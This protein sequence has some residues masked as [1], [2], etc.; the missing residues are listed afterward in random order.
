MKN[1]LEKNKQFDLSIIIV[2]WNVKE[3][4]IKCLNSIYKHVKDIIFEIYVVDNYSID[5]TVELLEKEFKSIHLIKNSENIGFA[6]ANNQ[7]LKICKGRHVLFLNPDTE[8]ISL[9]IQRMVNVLDKN[10]KIGAVGCKLIYPDGSVYTPCAR[11]FPTPLN[12]FFEIMM[13]RRLFPKSKFFGSKEL[14]YWD[15]NDSREVE[16]LVGA[17]LMVKREVL[18]NIGPFD[19]GYFMY[20]EDID[21]CYRIRKAEWKNYYLSEAQIIH[22]AEASSKKAESKSEKEN[23]TFS[24]IALVNQ[25][26]FQFMQRNYGTKSAYLFRLLIVVGTFTRIFVIF[27]GMLLLNRINKNNELFNKKTLN[28]YKKVLRWALFG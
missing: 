24:K 14:L 12:S 13:L 4:L 27:L 16:C 22:H 5:D 6:R 23:K 21:I 28:K 19:E 1:L 7:A 26:N 11:A 15:R 3:L 17:C 18:D 10:Q 8:V 25:A 2:S 9:S 20:G